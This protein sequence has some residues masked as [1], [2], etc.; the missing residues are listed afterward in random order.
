[1]DRGKESHSN[2]ELWKKEFVEVTIAIDTRDRNLFILLVREARSY[3]RH[4]Y[5]RQKIQ[6]V[7]IGFLNIRCPEI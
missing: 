2:L 4:L 1:M 3:R 6:S 5:A 7:D